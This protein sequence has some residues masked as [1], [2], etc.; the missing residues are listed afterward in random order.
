MI[1][2]LKVILN[3]EIVVDISYL[4]LLGFYDLPSSLFLIC[5]SLSILSFKVFIDCVVN[6]TSGISIE[7][8]RLLK[9][10]MFLGIQY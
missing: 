10:C 7:M 4:L 6:K 2:D 1:D 3:R 9:S 8:A 5:C